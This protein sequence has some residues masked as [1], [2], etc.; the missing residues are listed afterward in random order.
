[1]EYLSEEQLNATI[2]DPN[3][4]KRHMERRTL[5]LQDTPLA[6]PDWTDADQGVQLSLFKEFLGMFEAKLS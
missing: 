1:M 6:D 2:S 5:E 4:W 3:F